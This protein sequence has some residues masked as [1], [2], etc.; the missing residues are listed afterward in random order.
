[1]PVN[2]LE[3][4]SDRL[5]LAQYASSILQLK[6]IFYSPAA[7]FKD[8][9]RSLNAYLESNFL[10]DK[11]EFFCNIYSSNSQALADREISKVDG[12]LKAQVKRFVVF[13]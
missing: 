7:C 3:F 4:I 11:N 2:L 10:S 1:M 8:D 5:Y 9:L 6:A 13:N 12:Y